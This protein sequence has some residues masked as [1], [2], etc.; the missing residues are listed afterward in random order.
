MSVLDPDSPVM[1]LDRLTGIHTDAIR[2][3]FDE[4]LN[5]LKYLEDRP[6][7]QLEQLG[8]VA[9]DAMTFWFKVSSLPEDREGRRQALADR[10]SSFF[11]R[12]S[13]YAAYHD[14]CSLSAEALKTRA[15]T[16]QSADNKS[17]AMLIYPNQTLGM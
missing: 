16:V 8:R 14:S 4:R 5:R 17:L 12:V 7:E 13:R 10:L 1:Q 15:E 11:G 6:V 2:C 9:D 3:V